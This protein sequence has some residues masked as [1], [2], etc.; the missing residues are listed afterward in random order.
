MPLVTSAEACRIGG[1][2]PD[3]SLHALP[4]V[5]QGPD[6]PNAIRDGAVDGGAVDGRQKLG[7]LRLK[8]RVG[9]PVSQG[10]SVDLALLGDFLVAKL[11]FSFAMS[12]AALILVAVR[13]N[14][15]VSR[16]GF[17]GA[18]RAR[19]RPL[20]TRNFRQHLPN[21][22]VASRR[23]RMSSHQSFS[24]RASN[25]TG[26]LTFHR[27]RRSVAESHCKSSSSNS[28]WSSHRTRFFR[29]LQASIVGRRFFAMLKPWCLPANATVH[30]LLRP[31]RR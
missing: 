19:F 3:H 1:P 14:L 25:P 20:G 31:V 12:C 30:L 29:R 24:I 10:P 26:T 13:A 28:T 27:V 22:W 5:V 8:R 16:G 21:S 18:R 2:R 4:S 15:V 6:A 11:I 9:F 7:H 23:P 17:C